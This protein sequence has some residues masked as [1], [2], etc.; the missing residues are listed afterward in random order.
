V[1]AAA[2]AAGAY[3]IVT[4]DIWRIAGALSWWRLALIN[5]FALA[6]I[7]AAM[8]AVHD[9]WERAPDRRVRDQVV[10]FNV[11]TV[12]T[13]VLGILTLYAAL[14]LLILAGAELVVTPTVFV[15][16]LGHDQSQGD[17][18]RLAWFTAS[19]ATVGGAL[20]A[21]LESHEAVREAA[22][23]ATPAGTGVG[24]A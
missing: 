1:L 21:G 5:A 12:V 17:Y 11:V 18:L 4:G 24:A 20:A 13:V 10:L 8:V 7:S 15:D 19:L 14:F 9:L 3:G 2:F 22:Y 23:S 16:R 6:V